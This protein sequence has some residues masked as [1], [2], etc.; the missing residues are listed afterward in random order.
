MGGALGNISEYVKQ[1]RKRLNY[2]K[3]RHKEADKLEYDLFE[4]EVSQ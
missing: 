2:I 1:A 3:V 4:D